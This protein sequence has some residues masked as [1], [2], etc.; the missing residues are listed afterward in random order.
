MRKQGSAKEIQIG[1]NGCSS[2]TDGYFDKYL[3]E[4]QWDEGE[5]AEEEEGSELTAEN[6]GEV[7]ESILL[8]KENNPLRR[9]IPPE[10]VPLCWQDQLRKAKVWHSS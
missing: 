4:L 8:L 3:E 6:E 7:E 5:G 2:L 10:T 1:I 9:K